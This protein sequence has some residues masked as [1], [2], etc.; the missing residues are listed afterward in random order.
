MV[1]FS[2]FGKVLK[3]STAPQDYLPGDMVCWDLGKGVKH[4]GMIVKRKSADEQ[5]YMVVHNIG[6]GQVAEDCLFNFTII[7]HY[8]YEESDSSQ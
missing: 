2:R 3:I 4:I 7:G 8:R 5:R 1:F 6:K